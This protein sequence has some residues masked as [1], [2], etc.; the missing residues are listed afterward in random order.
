M[1]SDTQGE[2][3]FAN[4]GL[5]AF[6]I[7]GDSIVR[8]PLKEQYDTKAVLDV[9][10]VVHQDDAK[11]LGTGHGLLKLSDSGERL[12]FGLEN[13]FIN[14]T[15]HDMLSDGEGKLWISTNNG[16]YRFDPATEDARFSPVRTA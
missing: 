10:S 11:W 2:L 7:D 6:V 8:V 4:R 12:F 3:L 16:L 1:D 13:G 14:N 5:G 15:I 9:F